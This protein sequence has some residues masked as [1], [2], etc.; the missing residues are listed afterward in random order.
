M[1]KSKKYLTIS[2][3]VVLIAV[4]IISFAGMFLLKSKPVILQGQ[5]EATEIRISGKLPGRID[6]FLV[7][8]GQNVKAGDTLVVINSP[9]ALAKYQQVN[10]FE[11]I[12]RFQNQK[13]DEVSRKQIIATVQQLWNKSKSDLELAKTTYNRIE[14]LYKDSVVSSQRRDE[15]KAL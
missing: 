12:A 7:K 15:V 14:A 9:E 5:I 11:N 1:D 6:T 3:I 2:F 10:A 8:E 13:V 4:I